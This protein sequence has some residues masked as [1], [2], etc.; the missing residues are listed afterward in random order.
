MALPIYVA[1]AKKDPT[2][3]EFNLRTGICYLKTNGH[4]SLAESYLLA[5][6]KSPK[7]DN[8]V[9]LYLGEAYQD[10]LKFDDAIKAYQTFE[11]KCTKDEK[12]DADH[13]I[14]QCRN[15][16][17]L[18]ATPLDVTF[19]DLPKEINSEFPDYYPFVTSDESMLIF[20][21]RRKG[22]TGAT[23]VEMDGYYAS[24]IW[25]S[26]SV[27]GVWGKAKNAGPGVNG[28]YDEQCTGLS[29]DGKTM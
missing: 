20:T 26:K 5:A 19:A 22:N 8:S 10:E 9:W 11:L 28:N 24:D 25:Y 23:S 14:E 7:A 17:I 18:V 15:G 16:K 1:L 4:R 27:N 13:R 2:N 21:S 6:S 12:T 29:A 3:F